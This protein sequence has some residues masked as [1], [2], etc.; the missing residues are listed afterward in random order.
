MLMQF[1]NMLFPAL[2]MR[3]NMQHDPK[4]ER[5]GTQLLI[6][7][8]IN[9]LPGEGSRYGL[10]VAV[11]S[12]NTASV[13]PP[14]AFVVEVYAVIAVKDSTLDAETEAKQVL[15]NGLSII[16]GT[17]RERLAELTARAP[18]ERFLINPTPL[19]E[20]AQITFI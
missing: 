13:N 12:D 17:V 14:Y 7:H 2:E 3:T 11:S 6:N 9:K 1:E 20:P 18:W 19:S 10:G 16:M 4:G 8:Q 15:A 5:A